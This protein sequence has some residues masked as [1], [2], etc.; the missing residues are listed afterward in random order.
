MVS[1]FLAAPQVL[2]GL[3]RERDAA[4]TTK[5]AVAQQAP[6]QLA[7][8]AVA[9]AV[10]GACAL[11][12]QT[13]AAALWVASV[14]VCGEFETGDVLQ[15]LA[16]SSWMVSNLLAALQ[17]LDGLRRERDAAATTKGAVAQQAT[18]QAAPSA[19]ALAVVGACALA[20]QTAA[21]ALWDA[22]A[23]FYGELETGDVLQ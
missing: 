8:S 10:V 23:F 22:S 7:L 20:F 16:A 17:V 19:M 15:L 12:F 21:A 6:S 2:D 5:G 9:L 4:A 11:A 18:S 14:F 3:R 1:N 13:A